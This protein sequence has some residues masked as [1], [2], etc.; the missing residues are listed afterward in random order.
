MCRLTFEL[1][2]RRRQD[3]RARPVRMLRVQQ[4]GHWRPAVGA[5]LERGV[6]HQ[7]TSSR[8][9]FFPGLA[10]RTDLRQT[11]CAATSTAKTAATPKPERNQRA[12]SR[13]AQRTGLAPGRMTSTLL[14]DAFRPPRSTAAQPPTRCQRGGPN[15]HDGSE[16][17]T[18][19]AARPGT[20]WWALCSVFNKSSRPTP[21]TLHEHTL[22]AV[23]GI[24]E[25]W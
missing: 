17:T 20:T 12:P 11:C 1:S 9:V 15:E 3:D 21:P 14:R 22:T 19:Y 5:P 23:L 6:M 25:Q 2:G 13:P 7:P 8:K 24:K 18:G 10:R 4:A 16:A